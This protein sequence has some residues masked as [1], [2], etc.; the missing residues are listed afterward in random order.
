MKSTVL[1]FDLGGVLINWT[2]LGELRRLT[3]DRFSH[4]QIRRR[5]IANPRFKDFERGRCDPLTFAAASIAE[6]GLP[7]GADEFID[8]FRSWAGRP[9]PGVFKSL[10]KLRGRFTLAC[11]SNTNELHWDLLLQEVGV[12]PALDHHFASHLMGL[13]K[14]EAA[15]YRHVLTA[16]DA[17]PQEV[18]F[19]DDG[20]E[21]VEAAKALGLDAHLVDAQQ[22][23]HPVLARLGLI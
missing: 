3:G 18:V 12:G 4:E 2:G 1:L 5:M 23:V 6:W 21:N 16:L 9:Y 17:R 8:V 7:F 13:A 20:P 19:F 10:A 22:G 11:L 14:P 15:A